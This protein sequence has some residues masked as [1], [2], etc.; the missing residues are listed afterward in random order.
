M[1]DALVIGRFQGVHIGHADLFKQL[2]ENGVKKVY[3]GVGTVPEE[4]FPNKKNMFSFYETRQ[5]LEPVIKESGL[6]YELKQIPDINNPPKY[7]E[8]VKEFFPEMNENNTFVFSGNSYTTDCFT[9]YGLN[10]EI[11]DPIKRN[12]EDLC[13]TVVRQKIID[14]DETW[15]D[16]VPETTEQ[17]IDNHAGRYRI[18]KATFRN[19]TPTADIIVDYYNDPFFKEYLGVVLIERKYF[20][21]G[22]ALP[23]G[24]VEYGDTYQHTCFHELRDETGLIVPED[25]F[26]LVGIADDPNR[27][28]REHKSSV[29]YRTKAFGPIKADDDAKNVQVYAPFKWP[30]LA[31]DHEN[32]LQ[33]YFRQRKDLVA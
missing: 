15:R 19:P 27:D 10:Y 12:G 5:M 33:K 7:G 23:G 18:I 8:Y 17:I 20:P 32:I 14:Q 29:V 24:H 30:K 9:N 16:L 6:E 25:S 3:V 11:K 28:P 22:W 31:F 26:E 21:K 4:D 13:A 2:V 1:K